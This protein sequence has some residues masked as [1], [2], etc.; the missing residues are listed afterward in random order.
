MT[1]AK[2]IKDSFVGSGLTDTEIKYGQ[3]RHAEYR[4]TYP[5]LNKLSN[6]QL[7]EELVWL[8]CLHERFKTQ[9]GA[10]TKPKKDP[11]TGEMKSESVPKHLQES[12]SNNLAQM[13][14][15]KTK[16]GLFEDQQS[17]DA[18]K[19]LEA[20]EKKFAQYRKEHPLDFK[21]TCPHCTKIYFLKRRTKDFEEFISPFY[22]DDKVLKNDELHA[23][24]KE[25]ILPSDRYAKALG[26]SPDYILWL[27]EHIYKNGKPKEA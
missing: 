12:I 3:S 15:L 20:T 26:V 24:W 9:I 17:L 13:I 21:T 4:K 8:E 11:T 14:D 5:Q 2:A 19:D 25:G 22:A 18:F 6:L 10:V 1:K 23:C 27:D 16:L 7:L